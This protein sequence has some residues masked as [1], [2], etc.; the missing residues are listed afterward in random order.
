MVNLRNAVI[1]IFILCGSFQMVY[2]R[3]L[4]QTNEQA[5]FP[6]HSIG[7]SLWLMGNF[8][9]GDP[10]NYYQLNYG[11][12]LSRRDAI[13]V[14]AITWTY[15]EPEGTY[16]SSDELYPGKIR[17]SGVGVGYQRFLWKNLF[18]SVQANPF[19]QQYYDSTDDKIQNGFQLFCQL[20]LGYRFEMLKDRWFIEP[21]LAF[22]YWPVNT[23]MPA[24]FKAVENGNPKYYLFEPGLHFGY[25]F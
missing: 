6:R 5:D 22:N 4:A 24:S 23:N 16:G 14:E 25:T 7:S 8:A 17:S 21:S 15:Y 12:R 11:Y 9:P 20:R 10:P 1:S 3:D 19:L 13:F 2:C 18:S